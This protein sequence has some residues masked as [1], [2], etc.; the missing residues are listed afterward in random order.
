LNPERYPGANKVFR[1][2]EVSFIIIEELVEEGENILEYLR[3]SKVWEATIKE[4]LPKFCKRISSL[5]KVREETL[6][7]FL[8]LIQN[9]PGTRVF[10]KE[11]SALNLKGSR[12]AG[13][14]CEITGITNEE[15]QKDLKIVNT[16]K[17]DF[18]TN[19][20]ISKSDDSDPKYFD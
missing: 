3:I 13:Q 10:L 2:P 9:S 5:Y 14:I 20:F 7:Y 15:Y 16:R 6:N 19:R 17:R 1:I 8:D 4:Y 11:K 12:I 18:I